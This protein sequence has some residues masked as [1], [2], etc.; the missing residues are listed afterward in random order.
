MI[1]GVIENKN[2]AF[3]VA[4]EWLWPLIYFILYI[5]LIFW[6]ILYFIFEDWS[7]WTLWQGRA[8]A[9]SVRANDKINLKITR[10]KAGTLAHG[11]QHWSL[12]ME[13][14][15]TWLGLK[16]TT[17][18]ETFDHWAIVPSHLTRRS[19]IGSQETLHMKSQ[20]LLLTFMRYH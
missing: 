8:T 3:S 1:P 14:S 2:V 16:G 17:P 7:L 6:S 10:G 20:Q 9:L 11:S 4:F 5:L 19:G 15:V 18:E 13:A 12:W